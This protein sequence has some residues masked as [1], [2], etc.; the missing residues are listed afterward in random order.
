MKKDLNYYKKLD[1]KFKD[2]K[3][4]F[5]YLTRDFIFK[6]VFGSNR[7]I[8]KKMLISVLHL[9]LAINKS[10]MILNNVELPKDLEKEY[11]KKVDILVFLEPNLT[12]NVEVN[13]ESSLTN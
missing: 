1:L 6:T 11:Q 12:V 9:N 7:N 13:S 8:L 10:K 3:H 5:F 2:G 4:V